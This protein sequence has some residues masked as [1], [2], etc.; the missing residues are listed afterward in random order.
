M[1]MI[2]IN[3]TNA[4]YKTWKLPTWYYYMGYSSSGDATQPEII[5]L[6]GNTFAEYC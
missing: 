1:S 5:E 4:G 2:V 3:D 6:C